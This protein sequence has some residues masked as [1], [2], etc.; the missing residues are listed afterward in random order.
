LP[1]GEELVKHARSARIVADAAYHILTRS[2]KECTGQ[3]FVDEDVLRES[4]IEDLEQYAVV[5]GNKL[6]ADIFLD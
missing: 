3:F 5:T 4:G 1:G 6:H 2:A